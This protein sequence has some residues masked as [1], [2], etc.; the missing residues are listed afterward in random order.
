VAGTIAAEN[1]GFGVTGVAYSAKIMPVKVLSDSGSGSNAGIASGIRYAVNNGAN[2]INLSLGGGSGDPTLQSAIQYAWDRGVAVLMAAGNSGLASPGYPAAYASSWGMAIGAVNSN[3]L[4]ASFS[5]RA[6]SAVLD[7][8]TAA[9]VAVTSTT[10]NNTYATYDGTSMATPHMAGAMALLMQ[11]NL[12]SGRNLSVGQLE[13]LFTATASNTLASAATSPS[14]ST[15]TSPSAAVAGSALP[16]T[17]FPIAGFTSGPASPPAGQ[18][19]GSVIH[20]ISGP[21]E[22][23]LASSSTA[24]ASARGSSPSSN[25][26]SQGVAVGGATPSQG[27]GQISGRGP[28][29]VLVADLFTNSPALSRRGGPGALDPLTNLWDLFGTS[30]REMR[31]MG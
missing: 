17:T 11:A 24:E 18:A 5:N 6:G 3:G 1:N 22:A 25:S 12:S 8:V 31:D 23:E 7:Y 4:L 30:S 26:L 15:A 19:H 9:G 20:P 21:A 16:S 14:G 27:V 28:S 2:V 29:E 10:P 13:Q